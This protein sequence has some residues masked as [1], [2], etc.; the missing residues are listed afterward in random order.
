MPGLPR[1]CD[2]VMHVSSSKMQQFCLVHAALS[3][4]VMHLK[5]DHG[6]GSRTCISHHAGLALFARG[7]LLNGIIT[8]D[9]FC[10]SRMRYLPKKSAQSVFPQGR[11]YP[12]ETI[13]LTDCPKVEIHETTTMEH[14]S[15]SDRDSQRSASMGSRLS[16]AA[17]MEQTNALSLPSRAGTSG[18]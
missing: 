14:S 16:T 10:L 2:L 9:K 15:L 4:Y 17:P 1:L 6:G 8:N 5:S 12:S 13:E 7:P 3:T 18:E 11:Y